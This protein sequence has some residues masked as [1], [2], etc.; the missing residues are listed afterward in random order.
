MKLELSQ[1]ENS[2]MLNRKFGEAFFKLCEENQNILIDKSIIIDS[3][4][5]YSPEKQTKK[6][7]FEIINDNPYYVFVSRVEN[8]ENDDNDNNKKG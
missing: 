7:G 6:I 3:S 5:K 1:N 2:I 8:K 4:I